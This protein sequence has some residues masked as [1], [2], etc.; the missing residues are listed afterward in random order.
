M[1]LWNDLHLAD[2][3]GA[4]LAGRHCR[5][6]D[7]EL[8]GAGMIRLGPNGLVEVTGTGSG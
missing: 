6:I 1:D 5:P 7:S 2:L 3:T 4:A 8:C